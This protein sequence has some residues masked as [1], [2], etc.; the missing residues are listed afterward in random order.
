[1]GGD[2]GEWGREEDEE[3]EGGGWGVGGRRVV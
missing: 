3:F 2:D 1:M